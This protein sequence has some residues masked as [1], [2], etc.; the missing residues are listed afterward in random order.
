MGIRITTKNV[1][2]FFTGIATM[3]VLLGCIS[4]PIQP[5]TEPAN[6]APAAPFE[7]SRISLEE[8]KTAFDK[9]EAIFLDV[10]SASSYASS[11]I[12]GALSIPL[13]ELEPRIDEL[14][15]DQWIITYCT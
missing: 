10:R 15:P 1:L 13:A 12:P 9:S 3:L 4:A 2:L 11:H 7:V 5:Q 6:P 8:S 14:D